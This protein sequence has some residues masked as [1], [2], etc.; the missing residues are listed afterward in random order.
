M[1]TIVD[2]TTILIPIII[3]VFIV[4]KTKNKKKKKKYLVRYFKKDELCETHGLIP[5]EVRSGEFV[6]KEKVK[7]QIQELKPN[8]KVYSVEIIEVIDP[9]KIERPKRLKQK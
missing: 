5:I 8:I 9:D 2:F 1:Q 6:T 4:I 7:R 3:V